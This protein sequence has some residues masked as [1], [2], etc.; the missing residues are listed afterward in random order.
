[1]NMSP[2]CTA[3]EQPTSSKADRAH[4]R[5]PEYMRYRSAMTRQLV[6]GLSFR[7]WLESTERAE[8]GHSVTF[9]VGAGAKLAP[10]WYR[11]DF[12]P[13]QHDPT[14]IGPFD[15]EEQALSA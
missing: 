6:T 9:Q 7:S 13:G 8:N 10:G 3:P 11:H 2:S 15:T 5:Y 12:A 14:R 1:M 4:A